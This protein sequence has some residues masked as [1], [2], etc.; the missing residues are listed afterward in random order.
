MGM[1]IYAR[2]GVYTEH[3]HVCW[4]PSTSRVT[5]MVGCVGQDLVRR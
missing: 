4:I 5:E 2:P 1:E 3:S